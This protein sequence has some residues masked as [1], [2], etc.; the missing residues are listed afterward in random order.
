MISRGER[1]VFSVASIVG[2][3]DEG[4][5]NQVDVVADCAKTK[6]SSTVTITWTWRFLNRS[7][8]N[9]TEVT[10]HDHCH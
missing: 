3:Y 1:S 6:P 2:S 4:A 9:A 10:H 8:P 7:L 5:T